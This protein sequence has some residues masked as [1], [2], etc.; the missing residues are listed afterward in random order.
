MAAATYKNNPLSLTNSINKTYPLGSQIKALKLKV[1]T[2][3]AL[4]SLEAL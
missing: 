3:K 2:A 1:Q 4:A